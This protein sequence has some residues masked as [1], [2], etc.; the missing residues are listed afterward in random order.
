METQDATIITK[1]RTIPACTKTTRVPSLLTLAFIAFGLT[2]VL[3]TRFRSLNGMLPVATTLHESNR[4]NRSLS[5]ET[6]RN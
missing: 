6:S 5:I 2:L 1:I 3:S 4:K